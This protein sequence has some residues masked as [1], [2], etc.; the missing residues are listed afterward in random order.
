MKASRRRPFLEM[1][2]RRMFSRPLA[3]SLSLILCC[4]MLAASLAPTSVGK[5]SPVRGAWN[6]QAGRGRK[7]RAEPPQPGTAATLPNL[8]D[9][10]NR[11]GLSPRALA[12]I[13]TTVRSRRKPRESRR[14]RKLGDP[15]PVGDPLPPAHIAEGVNDQENYYAFYLPRFL[16]SP[17]FDQIQSIADSVSFFPLTSIN[18]SS[19]DLFAPPMPQAGGTQIAFASNRDG[20]VQIYLMNADG[21]GQSR[22]TPSAGNDDNPRWSPDGAKILFQ[23]DRDNPATGYNDIYLMNADG[24]GQTRLTNDPSDDCAATWSPDGSKVVFQSLRNGLYYQVY[25][26]NADGTSQVNLSNSMGSDR[27]PSW[28]PNGAK[29]ALASERDHAGYASIYVV[30]ANGT[31]QQRL[32]FG[33]DAVTD[34]QPVWSRDGSRIA[35]VSTRDGDK[36]VYVMNADGTNQMRLTNDPG[37]NDDSPYWSP[38]GSQIIFRSDRPR[39]CCDPTAQ[40]WVMNADG[41]EQVNLS[42]NGFGDYGSSW[43]AG[44][45]NQPPVANASGSYSGITG[46]NTAFSG[47]GSFDPDGSITS[48]SWSFGDGSTGA[49]VSP[50]HTYASPGTY[51]VT[52]TVTDNLGAQMSAT[53]TA[54]ISSSSSDQFVEN[55]LQSGLARQP[56]GDEG[57]YWTDMMRVAYL[58]G[59]TSMLV[60]MR[61]FGMTVFESAEYAAR[62][63]SDHWYVYD[64]YK[65][66]L[67]R[68]PDAQGWA[69]W[70]GYVPLIGRESVRHAFD[71]SGEFANI[72]AM[73]MASGPPSNAVTSLATARVDPFNQT[74]D[75]LRARDC[76]WGVGLLSLPG[77]TGLDLGLGLSYSSLVWTRS[78]PYAYFDEDRG[79]PS[80]GF[81][82]GFATIQGPFF[83][84]QAGRN[85]YMLVTSSGRRTGLRQV[86]TSNVYEAAD[87]SYLQLT[88]GGSSLL[89]RS[90][91]GTQMGYAKFENEWRATLIEDRNGNFISIGYDWRGDVTGVADTLGRTVSFNYDANANLSTITQNWQVNGVVQAH[92]WA[93]FGWGTLTMQPGFGLAVVGTHGSEVIPVL[94]QVSLDDGSRYNFEYTGAG[95]VS[96][97]HRYTSDGVERS[98]VTY[99]YATAADDCPRVMESR[100]WAENWA[101][102]N[103]VPSEVVTQLSDLGDG[104]HVMTEPDGT[105]Y[106]E[107]YGTGWQKGLLLG[108]EVWS[109]GAVQKRTTTQLVQDDMAVSYQTNPRV[110]ETNIYDFPVDA[111]S[112]RRR[113][114]VDYGPYAQYGLPYLLTEYETNGVTAKRQSY[115]DYNLSQSYLDRRII[116]LVSASRVYD[117]VAAEWLAKTTYAYDDPAS[118]Q[119]QAATAPGHDQSFGATFLARGNVTGISRWDATDIGNTAK[120]LTTR[121][122]YDAAG[123]G[124]SSTDPLGHQTSVGY[125]DSF[126]DGNNARNTFAYPTTWTDADGYSSSIQYNFDFGAKTRMQGPPPANQP[127]GIIQTFAYDTAARIQQV[128][129]V[130]NAAYT[131]YVYG[132]NYVQQFASVNTVADENYSVQTFDGLGRVIGVASNHPGSAGGYRA[133]LTQYDLMGRAVTQS[134]PAEINSAWN[135]AGDDAA[136]WLYTGQSYDWKGRPRITTNTD[137]TQKSVTYEG[138]GCAGGEVLMLTD[139]MGRQQK[140]YSDAL[141]RRWKTEVLNWDGS[142]YSTTTAKY[143]AL[144]RVVR[145]RQYVGAA[146]QPEPDAEGS[147]YQTTTMAYDGHGRLQTRHAPEQEAGRNTTYAYNQDDTLASVADARGAVATYVYN[148]NNRHLVNSVSYTAPSGVQATTTENFSYDGAGNRTSMTTDGGAGGGVTYHYDTLSRLTSEDRQFP[149]LSGT[150]TLSYEYTLAGALQKVA[151]QTAGTSFSYDF[152]NVGQTTKV[153]STGLGANAPLASNAQYRAWGALKHADYGDTTGVT[154]GYD[155]RGLPTQY[156]LSGVKDAFAGEVRPE[157]SNVLYYAD[158][159]VKFSSDFQSDAQTGAVQDR[160]FSYDHAGRLLAA[161]SGAEARDLLNGTTSGVADGPFRQSYAYD[162]WDNLTA[163]AGRYWTQDD[164]TSDS[165]DSRGRNPLWTYDADGRLVSMNETAPGVQPF[166]ALQHGY[167]AAGRQV[168]QTQTTSRRIGIHSGL[169][170]TAVTQ[171]NRYDGDGAGVRQE[172]VTQLNSNAPAT[173]TT[174]YLRASVL[175][176]QVITEYNGQGLRQT[177]YAVAGGEVLAQQTGAD[178][179][180]PHLLWRHTNPI[181]GDLRETDSLG[182]TVRETH[183]DPGGA[184]VG[185]ADPFG[186]EDS[187]GSDLGVEAS[188]AAI[189]RMLAT[190]IAGYGRGLRCKVDG[191]V[192]GCRFAIGIVSSGAGVI[193]N[194]AST[195]AV[196]NSAGRGHLETVGWNPRTG[197]LGYREW[198]E[199]EA[200]S[201]QSGSSVRREAD[202]TEVVVIE[203]DAGY[204]WH[205]IPTGSLD[206]AFFLL[207]QNPQSRS[208]LTKAQNG[209]PESNSDPCAGKRGMLNHFPNNS[210]HGIPHITPRHI[211]QTP[212]F[213]NKSSYTFSPLEDTLISKQTVVMN[214]NQQTFEQGIAYRQGSRTAYVFAFPDFDYTVRGL[215]GPIGVRGFQDIGIDNTRGGT[216]TNVNTVIVGPDCKSVVTSFPG[217]P[218]TVSPT[219]PRITGTPHWWGQGR[220]YTWR[221]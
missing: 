192:T 60:A 54:S 201:E 17:Y 142:V 106:K 183:L 50:S 163:R 206:L 80:P 59:Q 86:G 52:L 39:D 65:S 112:N 51:A 213:I 134:N 76:E 91:D 130:N 203:H 133:R 193:S 153:T 73:L 25:S 77:R 186:A 154:M 15:L 177:S 84:A 138:C 99:I 3:A 187:G 173:T 43:A 151:D 69:F 12:A 144:D 200:G 150:Y 95:Q 219:D 42:G 64:L 188:Q 44:G 218:G 67:R 182:K 141:G 199:N 157:G 156:S 49:G 145:A 41:S 211:E 9:V 116:G 126:S 220:G 212:E 27:Q 30:N 28:S 176:G 97:V 88:A 93:S 191:F 114:T 110:I 5:T 81:R 143:D 189:D 178:T 155:G 162:A 68:E 11:P 185:T 6:P 160:A 18:D 204:V 111:P 170:T 94:T 66:Y 58:R 208:E 1:S 13:T 166:V 149:G 117:S 37:S 131:R 180:S 214:L 85:V 35:F 167:D 147:D 118:I 124:L 179:A 122:S 174:Y 119:S 195:R 34:E 87:S 148:N 83:D 101:G 159:R 165:Y 190:V 205:N 82:L 152:D 120:A 8:D 10:R 158:G 171:T 70:E 169:Q 121:A 194:A 172:R 62:N 24:T 128:T 74:G 100:V 202:G 78:G 207:P 57:S 209:G 2:F 31:G 135:P 72:V 29:I 107:F 113:T 16:V 123:S 125:A 4:A 22:F 175:G 32:T 96:A 92:T 164:T 71:E 45:G 38:D 146:P 61:E 40:V 132:P 56:R 21:S 184:D 181:T 20:R 26:M 48:Y 89:L 108:S 161:F 221:N 14:G 215:S 102:L 140:V 98:R 129:T 196:Y 33:V 104:S 7:V 103:G 109:G 23:S 197:A 36:E 46:Q 136:G 139:E 216:L 19:F 63:R 75:Q 127:N 105:V 115:T 47:A 198:R 79:S 168:T 53:T 90:T 137:G 217:L 55:F 210:N